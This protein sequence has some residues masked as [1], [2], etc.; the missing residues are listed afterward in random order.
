[1]NLHDVIH[2]AL[3]DA[4]TKHGESKL[5]VMANFDS[6]AV[7]TMVTGFYKLRHVSEDIARAVQAKLPAVAAAVP[8][9][10]TVL[11]EEVS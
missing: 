10:D 4:L 11:I 9:A 8:E 5:G 7:E 6:N 2:K 1:V 3:L